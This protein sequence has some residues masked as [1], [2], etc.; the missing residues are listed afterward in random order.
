MSTLSDAMID[1]AIKSGKSL[2]EIA[3]P[4]ETTKETKVKADTGKTTRYINVFTL[5]FE[6]DG[7]T[8]VDHIKAHTLWKARE[9]AEKKY[10]NTRFLTFFPNGQDVI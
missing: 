9:I 2:K 8:V 4:A 3:T 7:E 1:A 6:K 10:P 5:T